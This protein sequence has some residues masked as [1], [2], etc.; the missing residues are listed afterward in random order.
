[1]SKLRLVTAVLAAIVCTGGLGAG[2]FQAW[3]AGAP[4]PA[5]KEAE[6][7]QV[8]N[9]IDSIR[10][11]IQAEAERRDALAG[12]VKE[13][14][15]KIQSARERLSDVRARRI[16]AENR[17]ADLKAEQQTTNKRI[18]E[19]REAL[20]AEVRVAYMNGRQEQLKL[21]LNQQDPAQLGRMMAYY[22]YFGRA[23]AERITAI[24][25]HL[26]HLELLAEGIATETEQLRQLEQ[27]QAKDVKE[28]AGARDQRARTL[29]QVQSKIKN[30]NDE[31]A[32]LQREAQALEK[33]VEELRR[34]IEEFPELADQ[35]F[36]RV[37]GKLPWPVKGSLLARFGQLRAGGP[38]KW[39]GLV[40]GAERGTQVR[41]PFH[42]RVVYADWL[43]GLGL[44]VVLDHGGGFMS[45][46]GHN[47]QV[48]RRVGD[49]VQPG[50]VLAAVGDAAGMGKPGLYFEIRKGRSALDPADWLVK[51]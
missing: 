41:A 46:Y 35:P 13:A 14:E 10:R 26:A 16:A 29:A 8:R 49:R 32:K 31:L 47:E 1:M 2:A 48:Y 22:G 43:P 15:L 6:L 19:Q 27:D 36:Q 18:D 20:A 24:S 5:A 23:R 34:A 12:Q 42:G 37:K 21:L 30:R 7:K 9:R 51:R 33:L 17:L 4:T 25:E 38:L 44:L 50:D 40:I 45:L 11:S 39:Q 3:A 28:L